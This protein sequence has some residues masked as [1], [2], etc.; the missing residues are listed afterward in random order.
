MCLAVLKIGRETL[1][2]FPAGGWWSSFRLILP[3]L[4]TVVGVQRNCRVTRA[5]GK[6]RVG[7][8]GHSGLAVVRTQATRGLRTWSRAWSHAATMASTWS[9]AA[10]ATA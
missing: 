9:A 6:V 7:L 10:R 1:H 3:P 5:G 2:A 8:L 4:S